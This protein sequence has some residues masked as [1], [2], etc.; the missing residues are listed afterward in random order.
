MHLIEIHTTVA[1]IED[2][3]DIA[4]FVV[5]QKLAACAGITEV[6]SYYLWDGVLQHAAEFRISIKT[7]DVNYM[8][9]ETAIRQHHPYSLPAIYAVPVEQAY[10]PYQNWVIEN[11]APTN[12]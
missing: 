7:T 3:Q 5:E 9:I 11:S 2:A 4:T 12:S 8:A 1:A 10:E 6:E